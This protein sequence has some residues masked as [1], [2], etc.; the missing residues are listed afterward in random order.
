M[1]FPNIEYRCRLKKKQ[2]MEPKVNVQVIT[3]T[4]LGPCI[5]TYA[6]IFLSI[7]RTFSSRNKNMNIQME[8]I[9]KIIKKRL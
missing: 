2:I 4:T 7:G 1:W 6:F 9:G 5:F 8:G 3:F